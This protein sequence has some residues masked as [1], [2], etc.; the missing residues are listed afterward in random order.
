MDSSGD[1]YL[2]RDE[3]REVCK[4]ERVSN[5]LAAMDLEIRDADLVYD[6][7]DDGN[8]RLSAAEM[9]CGFSKLKGAARSIDV[10]ALISLVRNHLSV[11][12][13]SPSQHVSPV[14]Q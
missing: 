2:T 12:T 5:W 8:D 7:T 14:K 11:L 13:P 10:M 1:G 9:V 6:L 4:D 3:F